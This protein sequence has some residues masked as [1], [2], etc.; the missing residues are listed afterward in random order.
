[1]FKIKNSKE[2][3]KPQFALE[4]LNKLT[5][6]LNPFITTECWSAPNVGALFLSFNKPKH[7]MTSGG[8]EHGIWIASRDGCS[9][10]PSE[11]ISD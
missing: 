6:K 10:S 9:N 3:I 7:W 11:R 4:R 8:L 2:I 1:M 5:E